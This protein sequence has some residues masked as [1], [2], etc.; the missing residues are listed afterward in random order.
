MELSLYTGNRFATSISG[1]L[2][3]CRVVRSQSLTDKI[4]QK[5]DNEDDGEG[6]KEVKHLIQIIIDIEG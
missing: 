5:D 3:L 6:D 4:N 1:L 2:L